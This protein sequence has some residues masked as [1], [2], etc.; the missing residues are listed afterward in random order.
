[1]K[2]ASWNVNSLNVRL[3]HLSTWLADGAAGHRRAAG[4]QDRGREVSGR[5]ADARSATHSVFS[6]QKTYNGV[7]LLTRE[8]ARDVVTDIP[9]TR[10]SAAAHS[11]RQRRRS[12]H[13]QSVRRQRPGRRQ[14]EI[15]LQ[16]RLAGAGARLPRRRIA[17]FSTN[18]R[19]GRF[20]HRAGRPRRARSG[21]LARTD[22]VLDAGA[23][24]AGAAARARPARQFPPVRSRTP[25]TTRWWDY[26]QGAF[27]RNLGLRI[28]L[29]LVSEALARALPRARRSTASR[30]PG[31]GRRITHRCCWS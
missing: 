7:A 13:R 23:R 11:D 4:N 10:R 1:M 14:R 9:G 6:G 25:A 29:I 12:A 18:D 17:A 19:A 16:A 24:G 27:R 26:R 21:R 2:I 5:G 28:D 8:P 3:P 20:Q 15:R 22:P 30:A 31:S